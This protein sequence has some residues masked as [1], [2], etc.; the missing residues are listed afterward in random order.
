MHDNESA[1]PHEVPSADLDL[2][3]RI[4]FVLQACPVE[5]KRRAL[6][7][8]FT[9]LNHDVSIANLER[10]KLASAP[11]VFDKQDDVSLA[12]LSWAECEA[13]LWPGSVARNLLLKCITTTNNILCLYMCHG[14]R[15][16]G[17]RVAHLSLMRV[18]VG[19]LKLN[20]PYDQSA[21]SFTVYKH[22]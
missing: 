21:Q 4:L 15:T 22:S 8:G 2:K 16:V 14:A 17:Q 18:F 20:L 13:W 1:S 10:L 7:S 3:H 5:C 19:L 9:R 11:S 6:D 12:S